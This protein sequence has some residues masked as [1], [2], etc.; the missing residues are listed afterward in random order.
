M[1]PFRSTNQVSLGPL[2]VAHAE[3]FAFSPKR[4]QTAKPGL[5]VTVDRAFDSHGAGGTREN[6]NESPVTGRQ[7]TICALDV[8]KGGNLSKGARRQDQRVLRFAPAPYQSVQQKQEAWLTFCRVGRAFL[9][10]TTASHSNTENTQ[11][12]AAPQFFFKRKHISYKQVE[13]EVFMSLFFFST[14]TT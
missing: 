6:R 2:R 4:L 5:P 10:I 9:A 3:A 7:K 1:V 14:P 11:K 8:L 12:S 13:E